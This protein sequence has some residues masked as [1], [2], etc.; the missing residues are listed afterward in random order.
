MGLLEWRKEYVL[1][2]ESIDEEHERLFKEVSA[3][4]R[5]LLNDPKEKTLN[6]IPAEMASDLLQK[7]KEHY[8]HE[9]S[10]MQEKEFP[11][12]EEHRREHE[13]SLTELTTV[14]QEQAEN[15]LCGIVLAQVVEKLDRH[16]LEFDKKLGEYNAYKD[17]II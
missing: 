7:I 5:A 1:G 3:L 4:A 6:S 12:Y 16:V 10:W 8:Q 11:D 13:R 14:L 2:I 9:E 15:R 17:K